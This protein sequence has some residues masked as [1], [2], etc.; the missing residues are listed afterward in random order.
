MT[1][2][3]LPPPPPPP[4]TGA[5]RPRS[6]SEWKETDRPPLVPFPPESRW[7]LGDAYISFGIFAIT[8]IAL[9]G[10]AI[11]VDADPLTSFWFPLL[12]AGPQLTQAAFTVGVSR[13]KGAGLDRDYGFKFRWIDLLLGFALLILG[14]VLAG[15]TAALMEELG[16]ETPDASVAELIDD[17]SDGETDDATFGS[18]DAEPSDDSGVFV[19]DG[20]DDDGI[21]IWIVMVAVFAATAVPVIEELI[22]RGLWWSALLKRGLHEGW[23]LVITS[24]AFA[25]AHLEPGRFPVLCVLGLALGL[26]RMLTGR[27]GASIVTHACINAIAMAVLLATI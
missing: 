23:A 16:L 18:G 5:P 1:A 10:A 25:A 2:S 4:P 9:V 6:G 17:A 14:F 21:T 24:L 20:D 3:E 11:I 15:G 7:G 26:G 22:Y 19:P 27:I 13:E 12:L 8:S